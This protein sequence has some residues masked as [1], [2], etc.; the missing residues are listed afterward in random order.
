V[1]EVHE[2]I[3]PCTQCGCCCRRVGKIK[4]IGVPFPYKVKKNGAC[5]MLT[6]DNKCKVYDS[7]PLLC[8]ISELAKAFGRD[9]EEFYYEN[10]EIC[11]RIM[12]EDKVPKKFRITIKK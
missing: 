6:S 11:N 2:Q 1:K 7:R 5:E 4:E 3:F 9:V 12:E 10:V 8:N